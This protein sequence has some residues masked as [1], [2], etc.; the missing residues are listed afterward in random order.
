MA[1]ALSQSILEFEMKEF[2]NIDS[3]IVTC[4]AM[5]NE[6]IIISVAQKINAGGVEEEEVDKWEEIDQGEYVINISEA[7]AA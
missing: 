4:E 6:E 2:I 5:T 1:S 3:D 7:L